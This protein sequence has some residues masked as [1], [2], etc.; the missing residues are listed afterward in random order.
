[1]FLNKQENGGILEERPEKESKYIS[2]NLKISVFTECLPSRIYKKE[3][4]KYISGTVER[5]QCVNHEDVR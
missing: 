1:M 2:R 4:T 3:H 5:G